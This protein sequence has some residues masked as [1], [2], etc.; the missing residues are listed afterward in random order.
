MREAPGERS[1]LSGDVAGTLYAIRERLEETVDE[2]INLT[3]RPSG[4]IGPGFGARN[5]RIS[6]AV[7]GWR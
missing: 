7:W 4:R 2:F 6:W 5:R 1:E 3:H